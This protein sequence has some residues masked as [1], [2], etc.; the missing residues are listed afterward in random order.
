MANKKRVYFGTLSVCR[1]TTDGK[2]ES[3]TLD[4]FVDIYNYYHLM[5]AHPKTKEIEV[6]VLIPE[7]ISEEELEAVEKLRREELRG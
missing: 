6:Y 7:K 2:E 5:K 1:T 4:E 3:F